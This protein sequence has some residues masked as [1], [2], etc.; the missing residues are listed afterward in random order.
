[1]IDEGDKALDRGKRRVWIHY[2]P[3]LY[4]ELFTSIIQS[5]GNVD[6]VD[7]NSQGTSPKRE[8]DL[9]WNLID[10]VVLSLDEECHPDIVTLPMPL[11][12]AK[13]VAFSPKGDYGLKRLPGES[14]WIEVRPFGLNQLIDEVNG[15]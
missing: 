7:D 15:N 11:P 3:H 5:L 14:R 10:V 12:N 1:M 2:E 4:D 6:I 8:E 9:N 13:V